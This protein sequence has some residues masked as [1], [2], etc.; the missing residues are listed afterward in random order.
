MT[1]LREYD[2]LEATGLWR[3]GPEEQRREVVVSI[4]EATLV[5]TDM[6]DRPLTHWS[7]AAVDRL[8]PG[9]E[10]ALYAPDGD[11]GETLELGADATEMVAAIEKLRRAIER[12]R[13]HPGRLRTVSV[14]VLTLVFLGL[15]VFWLPGAV[16]RH[17]LGVVPEI[18]RQQIGR[19]IL[20]RIECMTGPA[21]ATAETRPV[22][23]R[24]ARRTDVRRLVV[25]RTGLRDSLMLPGGIVLLNRAVIED[26]EDPAVAAGHILTARARAGEVDPLA[27]VLRSAGMTGALRLIT[28][29]EL[30]PD[31]LDRYAE[32]VLTAPRAP[33]PDPLLLDQF[34]ASEVPS[35]P[36]AYALD[37]TGETVLGLIEADPMAGRTPPPVL[38][39]RDW[40]L[41]QTICG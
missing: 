31:A 18:K 27:L 19:D 16:T 11:P 25:L 38:A 15:A 13:P 41:L 36:F 40:V 3:P 20:E 28:T 29:G 33:L 7:L 9:E 12:A 22:L 8:N 24:L 4:G 34:A 1:A 26:H 32:T 37:A 5:I 23:A 39:D 35:T 6:R 10:P 2:R 21:C 14:L 30:S 17:T